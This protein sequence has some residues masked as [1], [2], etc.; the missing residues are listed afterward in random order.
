MPLLLKTP[1]GTQVKSSTKGGI[2]RSTALLELPQLLTEKEVAEYLALTVTQVIRVR[3]DK[4]G[5]RTI[6]VG[7]KERVRRE[8]LIAWI[9][10]KASV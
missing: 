7:S 9:D 6:R 5:P 8:D 2:S 1:A 4:R 3:Y 10:E